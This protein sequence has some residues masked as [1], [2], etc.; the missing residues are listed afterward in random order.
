MVTDIKKNTCPECGDSWYS[1]LSW[2]WAFVPFR[3]SWGW[4]SQQ[5]CGPP[6]W[7]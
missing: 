4:R 7:G 6:A 3:I 5:N 1:D 2:G